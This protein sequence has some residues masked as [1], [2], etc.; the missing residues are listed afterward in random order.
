MSN[1]TTNTTINNYLEA[2]AQRAEMSG[3][4]RL[5]FAMG[6]LYSTLQALKLQS[7]ELDV[8]QRDTQHLLKA[9]NEQ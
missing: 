3:D 5:E 2:L 6:Y 4:G 9:I 7:Y 8:L 1:I